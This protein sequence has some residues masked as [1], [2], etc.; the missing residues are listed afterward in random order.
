MLESTRILIYIFLFVGASGRQKL[1]VCSQRS[2]IFLSFILFLKFR[3]SV[4][5]VCPSIL[6]SNGCL[7]CDF[8]VS[9]R[10]SP[11]LLPLYFHHMLSHFF[12]WIC[13]CLS[14]YSTQ[15]SLKRHSSP[16]QVRGNCNFNKENSEICSGF[17]VDYSGYNAVQKVIKNSFPDYQN[18]FSKFKCTKIISS[19]TKLPAFYFPYFA[20]P[21]EKV[22]KVKN[23]TSILPFSQDKETLNGKFFCTNATFVSACAHPNSNSLCQFLKFPKN[24]LVPQLILSRC[25]NLINTDL[26]SSNHNSLSASFMS[27]HN[28]SSSEEVNL[29]HTSIPSSI[30]SDS[31]DIPDSSRYSLSS[32]LSEDKE[33]SMKCSTPSS[34]NLTTSSLSISTHTTLS[35]IRFT[36]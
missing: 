28:P 26:N 16:K 32:T 7:F 15:E 33:N 20:F 30:I 23:L 5:S 31:S 9:N 11:K 36:D 18:K 2:L 4:R 27:V 29:D 21:I 3:I 17:L 13:P 10:R 8:K 6:F 14:V 1:I 25:D 22:L 34:N 12:Q 24:T 35:P 19:E